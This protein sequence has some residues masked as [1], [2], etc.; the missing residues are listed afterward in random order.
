MKMEAL[1]KKVADLEAMNAKFLLRVAVLESE[2]AGLQ[3]KEASQES[4]IKTLEAQL[5]E[6]H[7]ALSRH[8]K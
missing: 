8:T 7:H 5:A 1:E 2:K 6:S 4:R 3:S